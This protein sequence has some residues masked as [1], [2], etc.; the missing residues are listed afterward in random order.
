MEEKEEI[1]KLMREHGYP[2]QAIER[3]INGISDLSYEEVKMRILPYQDIT[4]NHRSFK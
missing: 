3:L 1:I 2:E 4:A